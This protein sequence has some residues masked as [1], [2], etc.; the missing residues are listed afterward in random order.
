MQPWR[1][2][3]PHA[4]AAWLASFNSLKQQPAPPPAKVEKPRPTS[5]EELGL[6]RMS[7]ELT[8]TVREIK[9]KH[10]SATEPDYF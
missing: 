10:T 4:A 1:S 8:R 3:P 6:Y 5:L 7:V 2:Q 9:F